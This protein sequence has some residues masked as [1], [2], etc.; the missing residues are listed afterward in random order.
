MFESAKQRN[1]AIQMD[2]AALTGQCDID[3]YRAS[4]PGGQKRNKTSSAV[5]FRHRDSGLIA[6]AV[7]SRSQHEN[8]A[9]ALKRLRRTMALECRFAVDVERYEPGEVVASCITRD[10][11]LH[12]GRKDHRMNVVIAELLDLIFAVDG[13]VSAAAEKLGV[14]TSNLVSLIKSEPKMMAQ[15][16]ELRRKL[17]IKALR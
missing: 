8:R 14:S 9:R 1:D 13:Q 3:L 7:E 11:K 16:N 4:G 2:D 15:V 12:V 17:G 5:R 6:V 10:Q